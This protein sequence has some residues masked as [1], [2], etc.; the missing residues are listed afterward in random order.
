[1]ARYSDGG[2]RRR[3]VSSLLGKVS[4]ATFTDTKP[5][6]PQSDSVIFATHQLKSANVIISDPIL[7]YLVALR[8]PESYSMLRTILTSS[9]STKISSKWVADQVIAEE[10]YRITQSGG[11]ASAFFAKAKATK[12]ANLAITHFTVH[13]H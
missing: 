1:M 7:A 9:D 10:R 6:Q 3:T 4:L 8:L 11:T 5:L 12:K 2:G 13:Q